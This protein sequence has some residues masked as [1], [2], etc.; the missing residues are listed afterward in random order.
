M[1]VRFGSAGFDISSHL[2]LSSLVLLVRKLANIPNPG[3]QSL[4]NCDLDLYSDLT[5]H[6]L[7]PFLK[8]S[9]FSLR[10]KERNGEFAY[11]LPLD[12]MWKMVVPNVFMFFSCG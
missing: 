9:W 12:R 2:E 8:H 10:S 1:T 11:S 4:H 6:G 7:I 5:N 3:Q